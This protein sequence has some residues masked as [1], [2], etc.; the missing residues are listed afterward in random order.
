MNIENQIIQQAK[1]SKSIIIT[2]HKSPDGDSIGSSL[3]LYHF[4]N[5]LGLNVSICH[6]DPAPKY[7]QWL[8]GAD[9]ILNVEEHAEQIREKFAAADLIFSLDYNHPSRLGEHMEELLNASGAFKIMIDH[10]LD[11][12]DFAQ[13]RISDTSICSTCQLIYQVITAS[14]N[15]EMIDQRIGTAIYLGIMTDTGSFRFN[16]V[17]AQTH[18]VIADLL[19][20]GVKHDLIHEQIFDV[21]TPEKLKLRGFA[22][23]EKLVILED[24]K[25]AYISLSQ[26]EL[27]RFHHEKGDTEGLV[28]VALSIL[29]VKI[30]AFFSERDGEVKISFRSKGSD[31]PVN[32]LSNTYFSGGGHANAAGGKFT[33]TLDDA[34]AKFIE[35]LPQYVS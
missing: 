14:G 20:K 16:S 8:E 33:G 17:K 28:N 29:G 5:K 2:A 26:E 31:H 12:A 1:D 35:I 9:Q 3:A 24:L 6:P 13:L 32:K 19:D 30:A 10:H 25:T 11:P 7:L 18:R 15:G 4:L 22:T 34:I 27:D 23:S 21:N